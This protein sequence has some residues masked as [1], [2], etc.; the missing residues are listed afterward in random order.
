MAF[1]CARAWRTLAWGER[2]IGV[3]N[4]KMPYDAG[5]SISLEHEGRWRKASAGAGKGAGMGSMALAL[6]EEPKRAL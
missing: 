6:S 5:V 3:G 4:E 2:W 1:H